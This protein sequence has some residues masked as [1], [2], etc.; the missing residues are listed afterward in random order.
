MTQVMSLGKRTFRDISLTFS[1]QVVGIVCHFLFWII[2]ARALGPRATGE[3]AVAI[4][5]PTLLVTL[6][7]LGI[8]AA[9]VYLIGRGEVSSA[10]SLRRTFLAWV[11]MSIVG[12][13][14]TGGVIA[15]YAGTVFPNMPT[16]LL[17]A[18]TAIFPIALLQ[19]LLAS[20]LQAQQAFR[21]YNLVQVLAPA[22][23][24]IAAAGLGLWLDLGVAAVV[25]CWGL[26]QLVSLGVCAWFLIPAFQTVSAPPGTPGLVRRWLGYGWKSHVAGLLVFLSYRADIFLVNLYLGPLAV[27]IYAVAVQIAEKLWLLSYASSTVLLPRLSQLHGD[28][29]ARRR[30]TPLTTRW[31]TYA[32]LFA[33]TGLAI[34][35]RPLVRL[36]FGAEYVEAATVLVWLLPGVVVLSSARI[37]ANDLSARGRPDLNIWIGL[38]AF[39]VNIVGNLLLIPRYGLVGAAAAT[40][41]S[42][43]AATVACFVLYARLSLTDWWRPLV[44]ERDDWRRLRQVLGVRPLPAGKSQ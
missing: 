17:W 35:T 3:F 6:L 28:D 7:N 20:L 26:G 41:I 29:A 10:V 32:A 36:L 24:L 33:A 12:L 1:Q 38:T 22:V 27:G 31:V 37:L 16:R 15:G 8:P 2:L 42:Y 23:S 18:T 44:L 9:N 25:A 5:V 34:V 11:V 39:L 14:I 30:L 4:L 19:M 13:G 21:R 43:S 40:T